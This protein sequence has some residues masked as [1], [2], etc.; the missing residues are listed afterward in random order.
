MTGDWSISTH[1]PFWEASEG[2]DEIYCNK[3]TFTRHPVTM[4][5][6]S[7]NNHMY[8]IYDINRIYPINKIFNEI[9]QIYQ[10]SYQ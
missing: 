5:I 10:K 1:S 2:I 6:E 8:A 9:H 4:I 3:T 7:K